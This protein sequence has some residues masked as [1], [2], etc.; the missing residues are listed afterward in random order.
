MDIFEAAR[1]NVLPALSEALRD[2]GADV[3]DGRGSTPLIVAVYYNNK[4]ATSLLLEAGADT[5]AQDSTGNTALMGACFKGYTET[6]EILLR[7][8]SI[9]N[10]LNGNGATALT[11]AAT[12]GQT[13]TISLLLKYGADPLI[14]D[15][16]GKN[17]ID[18]AMVQE[19]EAG[20]ELMVEN[21]NKS[22]MAD[23]Q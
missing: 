17:P 11:F 9:P 1:Q 6:A 10:A 7:A 14:K 19:N 23:T 4:E 21:I 3:R 18:Y 5:E 15:R 22:H 12:F 8:G 16:F 13:E 20:Y 2:S